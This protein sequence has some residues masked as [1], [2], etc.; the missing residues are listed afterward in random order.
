MDKLT[1]ARNEQ[2]VE[3]NQNSLYLFSPS[4]YNYTNVDISDPNEDLSKIPNDWVKCTCATRPES[5][6]YSSKYVVRYFRDTDGDG[7][8]NN[9]IKSRNGG[10]VW[11]WGFEEEPNKATNANPYIG[12]KTVTVINDPSVKTPLQIVWPLTP[13]F[14]HLDVT[15]DGVLIIEDGT[16]IKKK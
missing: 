6:F 13:Q 16:E 7:R 1:G 4:I 12:T 10:S 5:E 9:V 14:K 2:I 15:V 3:T 8:C 11:C